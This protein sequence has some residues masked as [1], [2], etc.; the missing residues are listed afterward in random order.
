MDG[1]L[2]PLAQLAQAADER[3]QGRVEATVPREGLWTAQTPQMFRYALL[4][5]ALGLRGD[6]TDE[7]SAIEALG[8]QPKLVMG[9]ARN[10]KLTLPA[11]VALAEL[12][13]Q[14]S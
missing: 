14:S 7:A 5:Q 13:L 8:L 11:D 12:Y 4:W 1:P 2:Q 10:F 3:T 6:F 9:R